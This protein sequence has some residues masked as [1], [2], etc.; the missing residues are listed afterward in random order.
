MAT[1]LP[2]KDKEGKKD[3]QSCQHSHR[4]E[5]GLCA[6]AST[7]GLHCDGEISIALRCPRVSKFDQRYYKKGAHELTKKSNDDAI[8]LYEVD[9]DR[10]DGGGTGLNAIATYR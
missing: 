8:V 10:G 6:R 3:Y 9:P 4:P 2:G 7:L 5:M 1:P